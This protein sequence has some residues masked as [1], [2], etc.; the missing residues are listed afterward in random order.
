MVAAASGHEK[1]VRM[2]VQAGADLEPKDGSGVTPLLAAAAN[3]H[4]GVVQA[5]V[6][7]G[8]DVNSAC[9]SGNALQVAAARG[10]TELIRMLVSRGA[11]LDAEIGR[12]S[13]RER[14]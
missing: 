9:R 2:L 12:A 3:D 14:E 7:A 10:N 13:C 4:L 5:L 11:S 6:E 8:A 1:L